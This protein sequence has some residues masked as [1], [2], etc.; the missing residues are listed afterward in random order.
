LVAANSSTCTNIKVVYPFALTVDRT[1]TK[2][3]QFDAVVTVPTTKTLTING[4]VSAGT[5]RIFTLVGTAA[6]TGLRNTDPRWFGAVTDGTDQTTIVDSALKATIAGGIITIP[7]GM[8]W[9]YDTIQADH[10][11]DVI[12]IDQ[13][14]YDWQQNQAN[15][16]QVRYLFNTANPGTKNAHHF[17]VAADYHP[18]LIL[19]NLTPYAAGDPQPQASLLYRLRTLVGLK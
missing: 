7:G 1:V 14:G 19:D 8:R 15:S 18:A 9:D 2:P 5:S 17:V 3:I 6:V 4:Y 16:A 11:N 12:I 13:S 10:P